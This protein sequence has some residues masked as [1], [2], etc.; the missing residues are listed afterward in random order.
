MCI[1]VHGMYVYMS[2]YQVIILRDARVTDHNGIGLIAIEPHMQRERTHGR[3]ITR[4]TYIHID[5]SSSF[6]RSNAYMR[7][8][9][10]RDV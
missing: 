9:I 3:C 6:T 4:R 10:Y 7:C 2:P 8:G 1:N 5:V